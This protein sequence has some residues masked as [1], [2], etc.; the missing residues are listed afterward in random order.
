[1][2]TAF[3]KISCSRV[4]PLLAK[5]LQ[6]AEHFSVW[7]GIFWVGVSTALGA[8]LMNTLPAGLVAGSL[9]QYHLPPQYLG[10]ALLVAVDLGANLSFTGSLATLLWLAIL[11][12]EGIRISGYEFLKLG[13]WMIMPALL[14]SLAAAW[15]LYH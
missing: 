6:M 9:V 3:L 2:F 7:S 5:G 8:N 14:A 13:C 15:W 10:D 1:L 12:R 4:V 11:R